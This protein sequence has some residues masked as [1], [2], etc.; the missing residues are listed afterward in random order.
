[1]MQRG[2]VGEIYNIG[3]DFELTNIEVARQLC[4]YFK[5]DPSVFIEKVSD[6]PFNDQRY[7]ID[8]SKMHALG[9]Q[10]LVPW[11]AGLARTVEWYISDEV[12]EHWDSGHVAQVL[13]AH[14]RMGESKH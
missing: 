11:Q 8:S 3:T 9:W 6:R 7:A 5:L 4:T 13:T 1:M 10:P 12:K 14:P 2:T